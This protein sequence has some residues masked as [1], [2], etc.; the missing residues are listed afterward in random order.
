MNQKPPMLFS[1]PNFFKPSQ[2]DW[3]NDLSSTPPVSVT[4]AT[5]KSLPSPPSPFEDEP[6]LSS[7]PHAASTVESVSPAAKAER[8]QY[9]KCDKD[10]LRC[11]RF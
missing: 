8:I 5:L 2:A 9:K 3:L 6:S 7:P 11:C 10:L 4:I 1:S